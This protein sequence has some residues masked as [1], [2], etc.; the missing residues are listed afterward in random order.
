MR[1]EEV[2]VADLITPEINVRKHPDKQIEE[3]TRS[4]KMFGQIRPV[5]IDESN[6]IWA[7]NGFVE[8]M[9]RAGTETVSAYR[10]VGLTD[11]Q[12]KKLMLADNKTFELGASNMAVLDEVMKS[13]SDFDIPGYDSDVLTELYSVDVDE[14]EGVTTEETFSYGV[15]APAVAQQINRYAEERPNR[16]VA[17]VAP[18]PAPE[19]HEPVQEYEPEKT[20]VRQ[21]V[22]CPKC[23]EK[24][25][26]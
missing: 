5:V 1:I 8:A 17:A 18:A 19:T 14:I 24:I 9:R 15:V 2:R 6:N 20:S 26:L 23:G 16:E 10:V 7:G 3:I 22:I 11:D 21:Y 13:L 4:Y 12:K 25:W